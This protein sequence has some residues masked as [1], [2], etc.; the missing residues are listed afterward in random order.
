MLRWATSM[1]SHEVIWTD[2]TTKGRALHDWQLMK[3]L[4]WTQKMT[5]QKIQKRLVFLMVAIV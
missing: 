3:Q 2:H 5:K 1:L 4:T